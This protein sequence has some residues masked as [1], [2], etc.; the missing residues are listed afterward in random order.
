MNI[1]AANP[2]PVEVPAPTAPRT[3]DDIVDAAVATL[4]AEGK[5]AEPAAATEPAEPTEAADEAAEAGQDEKPEEGEDKP[6]DE[7]EPRRGSLAWRWAQTRKR[8]KELAARSEELARL[9]AEGDKLM[10]AIRQR[11]EQA[12]AVAELVELARQDPERAFAA[13]AERAGM[14]EHSLYERITR[15]RLRD[16]AQ[17]EADNPE[18]AELRAE[19]RAMRDEAKRREEEA[20]T[21]QHRMTVAQSM[22][23]DVTKVMALADYPDRWPLASEWPTERLKAE[24]TALIRAAYE[25]NAPIPAKDI[26]DRL[27][28]KAVYEEETRAKVR[29]ARSKSPAPTSPGRDGRG[30]PGADNAPK[31][32]GQRRAVGNADNAS[33]AARKSPTSFDER[34]A[35]AVEEAMAAQRSE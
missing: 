12:R 23:A 1:N 29:Q 15:R 34:F 33:T 18:L 24:A 7:K 10:Q 22:E 9:K 13:L 28:R 3:I 20:R 30:L 32:A 8:E 6:D 5:G 27:E 17:R 2:Q 31:P 26:A 19:I 35:L 14:S 16:P 25:K 11:E 21:E 4:E